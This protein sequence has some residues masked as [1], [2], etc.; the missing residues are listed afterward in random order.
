MSWIDIDETKLEQATEKADS[1]EPAELP[2]PGIIPVVIKSAYL[3]NDYDSSAESFNVEFEYAP[4][5]TF[6]WTTFIRS[7]DAKGNKTTYTNKKGEEVPL[8]GVVDVNRLFTALG[9]KMSDVQPTEAK[10]EIFGET[11]NVKYFKDLAGKKLMI[12]LKHEENE[13][14]G[15][16]SMR[17]LI[18]GF[19]NEAG[20]Y[21]GEDVREKF[22]KQI[23][24]SPVKKLKKQ[25]QNTSENDEAASKAVNSW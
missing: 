5:K 18:I 17:P 8:P 19:M 25:K 1:Y 12:A 16:I 10:M 9:I 13:Y 22:S 15:N 20:L 23:E 21:K 4:E 3:R 14:E 6:T 24:K 11:K 7:G 2:D